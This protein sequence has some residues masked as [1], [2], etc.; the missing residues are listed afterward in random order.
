MFSPFS[1][2]SLSLFFVPS[3]DFCLSLL[4]YTLVLVGLSWWGNIQS[5]S[6]SLHPWSLGGFLG[7]VNCSIVFCHVSEKGPTSYCWGDTLVTC[8]RRRIL[9]LAGGLPRGTALYTRLIWTLVGKFCWGWIL[10]LGCLNIHSS[11][12]GLSWAEQ[13]RMGLNCT[14]DGSTL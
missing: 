14:V 12:M 4:I 1:C 9:C 11:S 5:D 13:S 7:L 3:P 10:H 8:V 2:V 6:G